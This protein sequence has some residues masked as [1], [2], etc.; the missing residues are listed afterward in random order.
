VLVTTP[1]EIQ[2]WLEWAGGRM[3]AVQVLGTK[4]QE[5]RSFW[6]DYPDD[7]F[8][9]YGYT[10]LGLRIPSPSAPDISLMDEIFSLV[11]L[12]EVV[13][14]RRVINARAMIHPLS[15]RPL[16]PWTKIAILVNSNYRTVKLIHKKGLETISA[17]VPL[18][19]VNYIRTGL[20]TGP[21]L[22][23]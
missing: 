9:A 8:T 10:G 14:Q 18:P 15:G 12:T 23:G 3:L 2:S 6:P 22:S 11:L 4:P 7:K 5:Y 19:T 16:Y 20:D 21:S 17:R 1:S 13:L